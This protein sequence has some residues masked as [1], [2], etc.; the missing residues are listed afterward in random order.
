MQGLA[1]LPYVL[2]T[3]PV[4]RGKEVPGNFDVLV[5]TGQKH[6]SLF[7]HHRNFQ[8]TSNFFINGEF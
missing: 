7:S 3:N 6:Y 2:I 1:E 5:R 4:F 8:F